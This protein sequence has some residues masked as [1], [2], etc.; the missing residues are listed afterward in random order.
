M[1]ILS[2]PTRPRST[3]APAPR[4]LAGLAPQ[5][6]HLAQL[7]GLI[8][9]AQEAERQITRELLTAMEAHGLRA[10]PG[11][12]AVAILETRTSLRVDPELFLLAAGPRAPQALTVSVTAA[13]QLLGAADLEAISE[14][15]TTA[16]LRVEPLGETAA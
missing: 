7:R 6:D 5:V 12:Q 13:R 3:Q 8:R 2:L 1:T 16:V 10:L 9:R 15:V 14:A 4:I 11:Q